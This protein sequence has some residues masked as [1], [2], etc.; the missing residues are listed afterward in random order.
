MF[1][2]QYYTCEQVDE[3]LLQGYVDD[4]NTQHSQSLTKEQFLT[5]L[6]NI[7][8]KET[9]IDN[10]V[11][12]IGYFTCDTAADTAAKVL[13]V[14]G[15][16]L[17]QGGSIKVKFLNRNTADS[18]T[19]N[20]NSQGAKALYYGGKPVSAS[21]SWDN[22]EIVEIY[23]DGT[24]YYA[25]NV[26]GNF[27]DGIF[28]IS[29]YN[30][31]EGQLTKYATLAEAL[32]T[33]GNNVPPIFRKGGMQIKY[34]S[35][36]DNRYVQYRLMSQTFSI[37]ESDWQGIEENPTLNSHNLIESGGVY[38]VVEDISVGIEIENYSVTDG[39]FYNPPTDEE[40]SNQYYEERDYNITGGNAYT[41]SGRLFA[42]HTVYFLSWLDSEKHLVSYEPYKGSMDSEVRYTDMSVL[43]PAGAFYARLNVYKPQIGNYN[44]K[45]LEVV[46]SAEL[47]AGVNDAKVGIQ[48]NKAI[49][50]KEL[51]I[52]ISSIIE[53]EYLAPSGDHTSLNTFNVEYF[54]VTGGEE[55][56]ISGSIPAYNSGIYLLLWLDSG[57]NVISSEL[58]ADNIEG[59]T[60]MKKPVI[61]PVNATRAAVNVRRD[62]SDAYSFGTMGDYIP[63]EKQG[64]DILQNRTFLSEENALSPDSLVEGRF[65]TPSGTYSAVSTFNVKIYSVIE[66][67]EYIISGS[68]PP[69]NSGIYIL[70]WLDSENNVIQPD[71]IANDVD[72]VTVVKKPVMAPATAVHAA[73]NVRIDMSSEYSFG[74]IGDYISL[75]QVRNDLI[76]K[77][78][79]SSIS[80]TVTM[81]PDEVIDDGFWNYNTN[82]FREFNGF[83]MRKFYVEP[84]Y[85]YSFS[86]S[87]GEEVTI[88]CVGWFDENGNVIYQEP[89]K[90]SM[91]QEITFVKEKIVSPQ[92]VSYAILNVQ[93]S[94]AAK[95]GFYKIGEMYDFNEM[96]EKLNSSIIGNME[97]TINR[98]K[99]IGGSVIIRTKYDETNDL[100][101]VYIRGDNDQ[102][103]P[104]ESY[105]GSRELPTSLITV[106]G[107]KFHDWH[108]ST[109]PLRNGSNAPWHMFAQH[110]YEIPTVSCTHSLTD[111]DIGTI[112]ADQLGRNFTIGKISGNTLYLLPEVTGP[113]ANGL[114]T[115]SWKNH[116]VSNASISTLTRNGVTLTVSSQSFTQIRP[117]QEKKEF[118]IIVDGTEVKAD[119][120]YMCND[121]IL[122]ETLEC[123]NPFT[124]QTWYPT[125]VKN[126]VALRL[127]QSFNIHGLSHRYDTVLDVIEPLVFAA[128]GAT[129]GQCLIS[130]SFGGTGSIT[131]NY[132]GYVL[133][134]KI[135]ATVNG[136]RADVPHIIESSSDDILFTRNSTNLYDVDD[137]PD[138]E[139]SYLYN[140]V[141]GRFLA[142]F[143]TGVSLLRGASVKAKRNLYIGSGVSG[144]SMSYSNRNKFYINLIVGSYFPNNV[145]PAGF[146]ETFS[147]YFSYFNPDENKGQVY[148]YKDGNC[149]VI[150]A[151]YQDANTNIPLN[152]PTEMDGLQVEVVEK[153][154][155][156]TLVTDSIANGKLYLTTD[157]SDHNYIVLK[158]K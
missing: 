16:S 54:P 145:L 42:G 83:E 22:N 146:V 45:K 150:Y 77:A 108:D 91:I 144:G 6:G 132:N 80:Q 71:F 72:G 130:G 151:H 31:T 119:G 127:V 2:S 14:A 49:L 9:V 104:L 141:A 59:V 155:G 70:L 34:V 73:V 115:R 28:D 53:R 15:Y 4:Y 152:L 41:F 51:R 46:K 64:N 142:G 79:L 125:P 93:K 121:L 1:N 58:K 154:N 95:Y 143:A 133:I 67:K 148:W 30:L 156:V 90:G 69:E 107:N 3:R 10:T 5:R 39:K 19:F 25:N 48:Q 103:T 99:Q 122:S 82:S 21:N 8:A 38:K 114:Y 40:R 63:T 60:V 37:T 137:Q 94:R 128:Y 32:G 112:W 100:V 120:I 13:T 157:S 123:F 86:A 87:M 149:Y 62:R 96:N 136:K 153:T 131:E 12:N 78:D 29:A 140:S 102:I 97:V 11:V 139:V 135:K 126:T 36:L 50:V 66:G 147:T 47:L 117:I 101:V 44:F 84:N 43:A 129:Q 85:E 92:N 65:L 18:A 75:E 81:E 57:N 89:Y 35:T 88:V 118:S 124:V 111:G 26:E 20:I 7:F 23:Y 116:T 56:L 106:A 113:D 109:S 24:S 138:R 17:F 27:K 134:P 61:A 74:T 55:Y 76:K 52:P 110:G 68:I 158:T 98:M 105:L 33:N